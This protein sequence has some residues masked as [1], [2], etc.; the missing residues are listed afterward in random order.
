MVS[1][2]LDDI[3]ALLQQLMGYLT[4][5]QHP[6]ISEIRT[7]LNGMSGMSLSGDGTA[8]LLEKQNGLL[9]ALMA[10]VGVVSGILLAKAMWGRWK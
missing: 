8:A 6:L 2:R 4:D 7:T 1:S 10:T 5:T 9:I 3:Y